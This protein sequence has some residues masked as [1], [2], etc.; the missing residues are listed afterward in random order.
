MI[1]DT[2]NLKLNM[3]YVHQTYIEETGICFVFQASQVLIKK[4]YSLP[5]YM[6]I[7]PVITRIVYLFRLGNQE[8]Y[9]ADVS[10]FSVNEYMFEPVV[11][12]Q[13][14][15]DK[16]AAFAGMTAFH[17]YLWY[18]N[19]QFCGRCGQP[20]V[21]N[22]CQR[23]LQCKICGNQ[24][25]P[26]ISP[27]VIVAVTDG[28]RLLM[29]RYN[30]R[31]YKGYSLIAGFIEVGETAEQA[32][33]REVMEEAGIHIKNLRYY[34]TQPWGQHEDLLIGYFAELDG[35]DTIQ[36]DT[37][38]LAEAAWYDRDKINFEYED[39]S[40]TAEMIIKFKQEGNE[41]VAGTHC[42]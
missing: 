33:E 23:A 39:I 4:N 37:D 15:Q 21:H 10:T 11:Q 17:L 9:L 28:N 27:A 32:A 22:S 13:H 12:L 40:L 5:V 30:G 8:Y 7:R 26:K 38:E 19:N 18:R 29:T 36:M 25:Y 6:E 3:N 2:G 35:D 42:I 31:E 20:L 16:A 24:I 34:K 14:S 1:Q 41:V